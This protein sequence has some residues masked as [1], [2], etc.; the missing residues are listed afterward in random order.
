MTK[1]LYV[2]GAIALLAIGFIAGVYGVKSSSV[3][4]TSYDVSNL[5]G[6]VY[7]GMT[8]VLMFQN[9]VFVGPITST[10]AVSIS[11]A[12]SLTGSLTLGVA[13]STTWN[14]ATISSSTAAST[15]LAVAGLVLGDKVLATFDSATSSAQWYVTAEVYSAGNAAVN[16]NPVIG[17][18]AYTDGLDLSTSTVRVF[19][20]HK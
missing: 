3:G 19:V 17:S 7:Q 4:G 2:L 16:I 1:I 15:T 8:H 5:V 11:G 18:A 20:L 12:T 9:G 6:D 13:S 10:N 14:P